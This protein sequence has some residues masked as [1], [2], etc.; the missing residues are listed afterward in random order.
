MYIYIGAEPLYVLSMVTNIV[1]TVDQLPIYV[2]IPL[3]PY[4]LHTRM[5]DEAVRVGP[6]PATESYLVMDA[7]LEAVENTGAQAVS[8]PTFSLLQTGV[9]S[10]SGAGLFIVRAITEF[11]C[12]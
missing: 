6:A 8:E 10:G 11:H 7:V 9:F 12:L 3:C 4:Q 5:A 1:H 2:H